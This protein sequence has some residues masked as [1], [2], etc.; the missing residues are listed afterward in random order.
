MLGDKTRTIVKTIPVIM[1][2]SSRPL[3]YIATYRHRD[4]KFQRQAL[5]WDPHSLKTK[6]AQFCNWAIRLAHAMSL[7]YIASK[8]IEITYTLNKKCITSPSLTIYVLPS[9]RNLPASLAPD[10]PL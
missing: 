2:L 10:S 9:T 8:L 1:S 4:D 3:L 6:M 5:R 7:L